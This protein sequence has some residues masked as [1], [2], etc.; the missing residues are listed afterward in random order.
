MWSWQIPVVAQVLQC[1]QFQCLTAN[2]S[3]L[4][5]AKRVKIL[6]LSTQVSLRHVPV[7]GPRSRNDVFSYET[8]VRVVYF[9]GDLRPS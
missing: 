4:A 8:A 5:P 3:G 7:T 1:A 2:V 6:H 9:R